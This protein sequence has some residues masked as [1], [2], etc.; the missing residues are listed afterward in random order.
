MSKIPIYVSNEKAYVWTVEGNLENT[1]S[2][3]ISYLA[4][5]SNLRTKH[6]ICGTLSGTL[7]HLTQQNF[8]LG[9]PLLLMPEEVVLL[10][11]NRESNVPGGVDNPFA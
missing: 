10:V 11:E 8:F 4:D 5:V 9:L 7:P 6:R 2:N 3:I 1:W